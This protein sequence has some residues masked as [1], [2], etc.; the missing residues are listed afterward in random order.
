MPSDTWGRRR[1]GRQP[2]PA[3]RERFAKLRQAQAAALFA[4]AQEATVAGQSS[5][6]WKMLPEVILR[7]TRPTLDASDSRL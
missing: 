1:A 4:L 3:S 6:A 7:R 5:T 2:N